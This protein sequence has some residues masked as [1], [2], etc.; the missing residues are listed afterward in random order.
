MSLAHWHGLGGALA[1]TAPPEGF[2]AECET[3]DVKGELDLRSNCPGNAAVRGAPPA[4]SSRR[5]RAAARACVEPGPRGHV[6]VP[7]RFRVVSESEG[8]QGGAAI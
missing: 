3:G 4:R 1:N 7:A 6:V 5:R 8:G 2:D